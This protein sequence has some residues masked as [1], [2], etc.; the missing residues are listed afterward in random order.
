MLYVLTALFINQYSTATLCSICAIDWVE[1][2]LK[3]LQLW[4]CSRNKLL[5]CFKTGQVL[6]SGGDSCTKALQL[7]RVV[8]RPVRGWHLAAT[9]VLFGL[10][11]GR[12]LPPSGVQR[13]T[14][15]CAAFSSTGEDDVRFPVFSVP[16]GRSIRVWARS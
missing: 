7:I 13:Q 14:S 1:I 15:C 6:A 11:G 10:L 5:F 16:F 8:S 12:E 4:A 3:C 9:L 2:L